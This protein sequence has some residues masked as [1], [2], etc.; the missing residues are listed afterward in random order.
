[1]CRLR[2]DTWT[3]LHSSC[4]WRRVWL[5]FFFSF[6]FPLLTSLP[7][8]HVTV[9]LTAAGRH[10][11][12]GCCVSPGSISTAADR[13]SF[14]RAFQSLT[15]FPVPF[16]D[17]RCQESVRDANSKQ[18]QKD[19]QLMKKI[20]YL[21][22]SESFFSFFSFFF[23]LYC[24]NCCC[25]GMAVLLTRSLNPGLF[26]QWSQNSHWFNVSIRQLKCWR[27]LRGFGSIL[28][29]QNL[30]S[31]VNFDFTVYLRLRSVAF[32]GEGVLWM[33]Q[34]YWIYWIPRLLC[35]AVSHLPW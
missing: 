30:K 14:T 13:R 5:F 12:A 17:P 4:I 24:G 7:V 16:A 2:A 23:S 6:L 32:Y 31:R 34:C 27:F 22:H 1:M 15:A 21:H 19:H 9:S 33:L 8:I 18:G 25:F 20:I 3:A 11:S 28:C 29:N 10:W 26:P 35:F